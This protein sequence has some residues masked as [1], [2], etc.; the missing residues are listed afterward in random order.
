[1]RVLRLLVVGACIVYVGLG[2]GTSGVARATAAEDTRA[3]GTTV[4]V[5]VPDGWMR[6]TTNILPTLADPRLVFAAATYPLAVTDHGCAQIPVNALEQ[7]APGDAFV[8]ITQRSGPA[9]AY[10][11]FAPRPDPIVPTS[12][13]DA[14]PGDLPTCLDRPLRG[15]ARTLRIATNGQAVYVNW[16]M[17]SEISAERLA[18]LAT[19]LG[20]FRVEPTGVRPGSARLTDC[21]TDGPRTVTV[22]DV[23]G[24]RLGPAI[25]RIEAA[26]LNVAGYGTVP[27]DPIGRA[28]RVR[29]AEPG[30]GERVPRGA[31]VG[32]RTAR[33]G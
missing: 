22:P 16:A 20:S 27:N 15:T 19:I 10:D 3:V 26:G 2:A 13:E 6:A 11:S 8:W 31:C 12:G 25:R 7:L 14:L 4:E 33:R 5:A 17:G 1:M 9:S 28:V 24:M 21:V 23:I 32:F 18:Q 29:A 30:P